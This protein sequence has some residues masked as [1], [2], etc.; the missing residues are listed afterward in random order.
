MK[1]FTILLLFVFAFTSFAFSADKKGVRIPKL[2]ELL[3]QLGEA[4]LRLK[5]L[6]RTRKPTK[7]GTCIEHWNSERMIVLK[8]IA[9]SIKKGDVKKNL[10]VI[11]KYYT[12]NLTASDGLSIIKINKLLMAAAPT[13]NKTNRKAVQGYIKKLNKLSTKVV[14]LDHSS[15]YPHYHLGGPNGTVVW[16]SWGPSAPITGPTTPP[17]GE[18]HWPWQPHPNA[19]NPYPPTPP[20]YNPPTPPPY[21]PPSPPPYNPPSYHSCLQA[22]NDVL[23]WYRRYQRAAYGS[24]EERDAKREYNRSKRKL[25]DMITQG[26][27]IYPSARGAWDEY[28]RQY[29]LY[30]NSPMNSTDEAIAKMAYKYGKSDYYSH[31]SRGNYLYY[32]PDRAYDDFRRFDRQYHN[33]SYNSVTETL[34]K[35]QRDEAKNEYRRMTGINP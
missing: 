28:I 25:D 33:A 3:D 9:K 4:N 20:P 22:Y 21:N 24:W 30:Q 32:N 19:P 23:D 16:G 2:T 15:S 10:S 5:S 1:K 29:R 35:L 11:E 34:A 8:H 26:Y 13:F 18:G 17:P 14:H 7:A 12:K 27:N 31:K 6:S